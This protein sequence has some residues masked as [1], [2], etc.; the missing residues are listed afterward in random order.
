MSTSNFFSSSSS[1]G[2]S[3]VSSQ[4]G[5]ILSSSPNTRRK[6][7]VSWADAPKV[8]EIDPLQ[9]DKS[10]NT[11]PSNDSS[12]PPTP[13]LKGKS[14]VGISQLPESSIWT[15]CMMGDTS[16]VKTLLA[17]G[18]DANVSDI[19]GRTPLHYA[20]NASQYEV[21]KLLLASGANTTVVD[22][23]YKMPYDCSAEVKTFILENLMMPPSPVP[24]EWFSECQICMTEWSIFNR[25][26][27]CRH[28]GRLCCA[29]CSLH[30]AK[31]PAFGFADSVRVCCEC[32]PI[33]QRLKKETMPESMP[34]SLLELNQQQN[35]KSKQPF[36][37]KAVC[38]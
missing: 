11:A 23:N 32:Y 36:G 30:T 24:D 18:V 37:I 3:F 31:L 25:R 6:K 10:Q 17:S 1:A 16:R 4:G 22:R 8:E 9:V 14:S 28:C 2:G 38:S 13:A 21:I 27:H 26:H 5:S 34:V 12:K 33:I 19:G 35:K 20:C 7:A 29:E 15:S